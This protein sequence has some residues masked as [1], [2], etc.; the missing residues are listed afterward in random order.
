VAQ[1]PT[2]P[3]FDVADELGHTHRAYGVMSAGLANGDALQ[4]KGSS[5]LVRRRRADL[6]QD[7]RKGHPNA[8]L[9]HRVG[10][11]V[12][13][14]LFHRKVTGFSRAQINGIP[15]GSCAESFIV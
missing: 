15:L 1:G 10:P 2:F 7:T 3:V 11:G 4:C 8:A 5:A 9:K 14:R 6:T 13:P 12:S